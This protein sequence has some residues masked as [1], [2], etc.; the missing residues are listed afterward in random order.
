MEHA[1]KGIAPPRAGRNGTFRAWLGALADRIAARVLR[2][3]T[4]SRSLADLDPRTLRDIGIEDTEVTVV[5]SWGSDGVRAATRR[6]VHL[7]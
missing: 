2:H 5:E 1:L 4:T 7:P 3:A 6:V